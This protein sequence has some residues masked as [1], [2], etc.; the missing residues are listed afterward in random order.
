M[1]QYTL[2]IIFNKEC[3]KVLMCFHN[4]QQ[5]YNFIGGT[6]EPDDESKM[7][8]S[9]RELFEETGI[10]EDAVELRFVR[11][12]IVTVNSK[13]YDN[14]WL[15]YVTY[16]ILNKDIELKEEKNKLVWVD[17]GDPIIDTQSMGYGNCRVFL[18]EAI[19]LM[20]RTC[21]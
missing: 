18:N 2:S 19:A 10:P 4:K 13:L 11:Q 3:D 9:Y 8:A 17:Y 14:D 7:D 15:M 21:Q 20:R 12:E 6:I 1:N 5:L 16:G